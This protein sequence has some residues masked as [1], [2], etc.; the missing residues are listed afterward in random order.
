MVGLAYKEVK[1]FDE[2]SQKKDDAGVWSVEEGGFSMLMMVS[3]EDELRP[4]SPQAIATCK[5]AG[6]AVIMVTG[7]N[8]K[9]ARSI[10]DQVGITSPEDKAEGLCLNGDD[11]EQLV[12]DCTPWEFY[13]RCRN[14]RVLFRSRP[15]HKLLLVEHLKKLNNLVAVTGDGTND[16]PALKQAT[17]GVSMGK[18]GTQ[19][20]KNASD[21]VVLDDN[22]E[23][24]VRSMVWGRNVYDSIKKFLQF[25]L[26]INIVAC[27]FSVAASV[28]FKQSVLTTVQ[29][30]WVNM[31]MDS[32]AALALATEPPND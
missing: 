5:K 13:E 27:T 19:V 6:V 20:A 12:S 3:I 1:S 9:T 17:V 24:I 15:D 18:E 30:L 8:G 14:L 4:E 23:S 31:I 21:I 32:L 28:L 26:T 7:D 16:A 2:H 10:A 29:M 11:F 22:F 25:Q